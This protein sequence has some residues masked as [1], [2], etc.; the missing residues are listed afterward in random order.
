MPTSVIVLALLAAATVVRG[1]T[2]PDTNAEPNRPK[3]DHKV[4]ILGGGVAGVIAARTF[5]QHGV[6]DFVIVEAR[7]ELG[8]RLRSTSFGGKTV[9][10]GANWVQGTQTGP[11]GPANPI[12]TLVKKHKIKTQ[13]S[14]Y[15]TS[16][17][18]YDNT[19]AVNYMDVFNASIDAYV[20]L[21]RTAGDRVPQ[22]LVD[23]SSRTAYTLIG[24]KPQD[25]HAKAAEYYQFDW[26][27]AQTPDQ[28][29]AIA[30]SWA[31]N[32]TFDAYQGGFSDDNL[33]NIDQR[34]FKTFIQEEAKEF[35]KPSQLRLSSTVKTISW[36]RSGVKLVLTDG[37]SLSG[38]YALCTFSL[39]VLQNDDVTLTPQL[40]G[41]K[42]EAIASMTMGT[43]TK[44]FLQFPKKFWFDTEMALYADPERGRYPVWQSLDHENFLPGSGIIFVT[45]TGDFSERIEGLPD[46]QVK[47]EVL[48][49]L[50]S[51]YPNITVPAPL[52]FK[53]NRWRSDPLYRG[54]Y[55]NWPPS[56]VKQ[57]HDNLRA[58]VER[59]YFAGEA[60]TQKYF[61][62]LHGAYF[63]G[64]DVAKEMIKC[65]KHHG[66]VGLQHYN[67]VK[68]AIPYG[69]I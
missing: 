37:S 34:G 27:Y 36:S 30:S 4:I 39:G 68:N 60:T 17:T 63:E 20:E 45:V 13:L 28:T 33:L 61:G 50:Q 24:A 40:P 14:N 19:G 23:V 59:L 62:F 12:F 51:M 10:L 16:L 54:S 58:N 9:E 26:E 6:K 64:L 32:F 41:F 48:G 53:F 43:Y 3:N 25:A 67:E 11:N 1:A 52:D 8:G 42:K 57:H 7:D 49:V 31:N 18:T 44:I 21:T 56:F 38:D 2:V 65:I 55:S 66:C 46:A 22:N 15:F 35:L 29:S 69:I 5:H 47:E